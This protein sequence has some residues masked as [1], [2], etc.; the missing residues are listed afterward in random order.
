MILL[1]SI[2]LDNFLSHKQTRI[3][4]KDNERL[5]IDGK[6]GA[7]KSAILDALT[8][9]LYNVGRV[10]GRSLIKRGEKLAQVSIVLKD[11]AK[12]Y[13]ITR[14]IDAKGIHLL[15]VGESTNGETFTDVKVA[16][17]KA[18]QKFIEH[19]ILKCSYALFINSVFYPQ[20]NLESFV[21][22]T[23][24]KRKD[25]IMELVRAEDYE[26]HYD[27]TKEKL[28]VLGERLLTLTGRREQL[29]EELKGLLVAATQIA[30][31]QQKIEDI[32]KEIKRVTQILEETRTEESEIVRL[33][34]RLATGRIE[35]DGMAR[36]IT[37]LESDKDT[38][39]LK[40][41]E[42][43][44]LDEGQIRAKVSLY[45]EVRDKISKLEDLITKLLTWRDEYEAIKATEPR[46]VNFEVAMDETLAYIKKLKARPVAMEKCPDCGKSHPCLLIAQEIQDQI[47]KAEQQ[48]HKLEEDQKVWD[49]ALID[50]K[51]K[52]DIIWARKPDVEQDQLITLRAELRSLEPFAQQAP[53]LEVRAALL[54]QY[55]TDIAKI[56]AN[57]AKLDESR[58]LKMVVLEKLE[59]D[60]FNRSTSDKSKLMNSLETL[61][62][63]LWEVMEH[64]TLAKNAKERS[65]LVEVEIGKLAEELTKLTIDHENLSLLKEAFGTNGIKSIVIDYV[66]PQLE[67][68]INEVLQP[69][70]DFRIKFDTQK[71]NVT[72]ESVVEGLFITVLNDQG[73]EFD[74]DSYSGGQKIKILFAITEGLAQMQKIEF[75]ILDE[76][77]IGLDEESGDQFAA[78]I[79]AF[80]GRFKQLICIS[81]LQQIKDLFENKIVVKNFL[82][83]SKIEVVDK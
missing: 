76:A 7:G 35:I 68:R 73:E 72:G 40:V 48:L 57:I 9:C 75:R 59:S 53:K 64:L 14:T 70:S 44:Q 20:E 3:E 2:T 69:L 29:E 71:S 79:L 5:L 38:L 25:L 49:Q 66:L 63:Q 81:H 28:S 74:Y 45:N 13:I 65:R 8:W 77:V 46:V 56:E 37:E 62:S 43:L 27:K 54:N 6:S 50:F 78:A 24:A 18:L 51:V 36:Q 82:G 17:T 67:L 39:V 60:I 55:N 52:R 26:T 12:T 83:T 19:E 16:G 1:K 41:R 33:K 4:F 80:Q 11:E 32:N 42:L 34:D 23:P 31:N 21:R 15:N 22:Q 30:S 61:N 58:L 10:Q 47:S